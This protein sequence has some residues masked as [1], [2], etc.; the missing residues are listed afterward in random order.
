MV[1]QYKDICKKYGCKVKV[2]TQMGNGLRG[3][4]GS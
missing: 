4:M 3:T 1:R 2:F